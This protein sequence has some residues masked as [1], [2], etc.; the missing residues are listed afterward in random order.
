[1]KAIEELA[2]LAPAIGAMRHPSARDMQQKLND[3]IAELRREYP[4]TGVRAAWA[5]VVDTLRAVRPD[6]DETAGKPSMDNAVAAI[7]SMAAQCSAQE[8]QSLQVQL[9]PPAGVTDYDLETIAAAIGVLYA[10]DPVDDP[11]K[12]RL[13]D[14]FKSLRA[15]APRT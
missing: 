8:L 10:N 13:V 7:R 9:T 5:A 4:E 12:L 3:V 15:H 14:L 2:A 6:W 1:M 11:I